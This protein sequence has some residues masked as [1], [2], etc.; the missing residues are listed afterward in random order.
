MHPADN[1]VFEVHESP[2]GGSGTHKEV[3][4]AIIGVERITEITQWAEA[5]GNHLFL[6]EVGVW[7]NKT[8][9]M[10]WTSY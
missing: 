10:R 2:T 8:S 4:S 1:F 5:T 6:G 7:T 9:L 3:V